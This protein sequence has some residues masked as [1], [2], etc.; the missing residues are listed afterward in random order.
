MAEKAAKFQKLNDL[1]AAA[2]HVS[3]SALECVLKYVGKHGLPEKNSARDTRTAN[4]QIIAG[5]DG[6]GLLL[7]HQDVLMLDGSNIKVQFLNFCSFVHSAY[8]AGGSFFKA[9]NAMLDACAGGD[10]AGGDKPLGRCIYSDEVCPGNPLAANTSRKCW[11]V[12]AGF[13]EMGTLL[14]NENA[15][16]TLCIVRS[17]V[18]AGIDAGISQVIKKILFLIFQNPWCCSSNLLAVLLAML[19]AMLLAVLLARLLAM[20]AGDS[21]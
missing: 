5:A 11:V 9:M 4:Q 18:V 14:S 1:R 12:Y 3:K 7:V 19:L 8:K 13:K 16:I 17:S 15:W 6:Y 2:P 21:K 10:G 20:L